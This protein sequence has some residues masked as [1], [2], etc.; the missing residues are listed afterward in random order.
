MQQPLF[1]KEVEELWKAKSNA[2]RRSQIYK[3]DEELRE[4][5][6]TAS[7][8]FEKAASQEKE[9]LYEEFIRTVTEDR[10]L[11]KFWHLHKAMNSNQS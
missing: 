7:R 11:H 1:T 5:A 9:R 4:V 2:Y 6:K 10:T 3:D 8:A